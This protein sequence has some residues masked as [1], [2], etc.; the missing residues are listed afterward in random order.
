M[1]N[2]DQRDYWS[3]NAGP[4]WVEQMVEM[5]A[6]L[7]P[8]LDGLIA[9]AQLGSGEHV[10]DIGCGAGA[11]TFAAADAVGTAGH[12]MG[13]DISET[14][15][16]AARTR[17]PAAGN[18]SFV[19]AD[20]ETHP[21]EPGA[22]DALISRFGV[23]FFTDFTA[24]FTNMAK[25]LRPGGRMVFATWGTISNNPYFTA[26]AAI[27]KEV[28]GPIERT[29]PDLPGPFALR[30][31]DRVN[32]ILRGAG[33][34]NMTT[35]VADIALAPYGGPAEM[36]ALVCRIGPPARAIAEYQ[37]SVDKM[38]ALL[39]AL[40]EGLTQFETPDGMRVPA[41]INYFTATKPA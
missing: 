28:L 6:N 29:D 2:T 38:D 31:P 41:E 16:S 27:A 34:V 26:P 30:E 32:A 23:M 14:L 3:D 19:H 5:D 1:K 10:I 35:D 13:A 24:A 4:T 17:A 20:A 9:R 11:S 40:T 36:A 12:V 18:V 25:A 21:F 39:S 37:P 15:L 7:A 33:M 8:V 22:A